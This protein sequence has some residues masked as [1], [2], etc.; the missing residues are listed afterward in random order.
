VDIYQHGQW[1]ACVTVPELAGRQGADLLAMPDAPINNEAIK[2]AQRVLDLEGQAFLPAR[3]I[4][5]VLAAAAPLLV[6]AEAE[7]GDIVCTS[8][9]GPT[10]NPDTFCDACRMGELEEERDGQMRIIK[11]MAQRA[12]TER[13]EHAAVVEGL[14][15]ELAEVRAELDLAYCEGANIGAVIG[16]HHAQA[17]LRAAGGQEK[18]LWLVSNET[19]ELIETWLR[20]DYQ[21][22]DDKGY[23]A[24]AL[25][26]RLRSAAPV[27]GHAEPSDALDT[28]KLR[29]LVEPHPNQWAVIQLHDAALAA[30]DEIDRLRAAA[31]VSGE[32]GG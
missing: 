6:S 29:L 15:A 10:S 23:Q 25:A 4:G 24:A 8:C 20:D 28:R 12:E 3:I 27:G 1:V 16:A 13:A 9:E 19:V 21:D 14:R 26:Q 22:S 18:P 5:A 2:A 17:A 11:A 32:Q 7:R 30:A 31:A